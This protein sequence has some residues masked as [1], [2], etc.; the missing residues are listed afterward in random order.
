MGQVPERPSLDGLEA[1]WGAR[2]EADGTYRHDRRRPR[3]DVYAIDFPPLTVSGSLHVGH[4]F[5]YCHTDFLAR[6]QRMRGRAVFYPV[7]WDDNGLPT[8][9]R[10]ENHYG[11][12][13]DPSLPYDPDFSPP[14]RPPKRKLPISRPNFVELCRRLTDA[15]E[16]VFEDLWRQ[17]GLSVDWSLAYTTIG[18]RA[19][20]TSQR[21]FLHQLAAGEAYQAEA[22]TL[23]DVTYR[24]AVAQAEIEDREVQGTA[25][26]VRFGAGGAAAAGAGPGHG[27]RDLVVETTRPELLPACVALVAHP[28]DDRYRDLAG[29]TA[30]T[31]LFGVPV[32]V[33]AHRLADPGKGTGLAMICTFGD[34]TDVVWWREL[35]LPVRSV[36]TRDGRL[37]ADPP[38]GVPAN[39]AWAELAGQTT[40]EA[41]RRAVE[42]LLASGD[43]AGEPRTITHPVKFYEN[44]DRP[45][46]IV[47]SRQWFIC[48]LEH[49][50]RFLELG[51]ALQWQPP[52]MHTRYEH[53]VTG[54]HSD[55]LVS[56][57]RFFGVP[58]PLWYPLTA[59][60][61]VDHDHPIVPEE[62]R[63]PVDPSTDV[64]DG[65]VAA[66]R[67]RP[68]GFTGDPDVFD[69][70]ATS[71][72]TP[73]IA[74]GWVEDPERFATVFPMHLRP[75]AH[76]IIRTWLFYTIV[77]SDF[78]HGVLPWSRAAISGWVVDPDRRKMSKSKGNVVTP[79]AMLERY[80]ADAL[81]YWAAGGRPGTDTAVDEGQM[82]VGRR[83]A[84]KLLNSARFILGLADDG[85]DAGPPAGA[86]DLA[87]L[88]GLD[89]VVAGVTAALEACDWTAALE[90]VERFFWSFCD[91]YLELVKDRAYQPP[92]T[93]AGASA[94]AALRAGLDVQVR[95]LAPYLPYACEEVWSWWRDGT[96]HLAAWPEPA[97]AGVAA[98]DQ[99][100]LEAAS[101]V[102][103]AIRRAKSQARLPLRTPVAH[104]EV[105]GPPAWLA[106]VRAAEGDL[107]AA[108][109][110]AAFGYRER[111]DADGLDV[112]VELA[113][114]E[115][116]TT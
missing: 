8:E 19:R 27:R 89:A 1:K 13:C 11:V 7:G 107:A 4:V 61:E 83:L 2:W 92:G 115:E 10:V 33:V 55:W 28:D 84:I 30:T 112:R 81:R 64:P 106:A 24:T 67:G 114:A 95:L 34:T 104:A 26:R 9:R 43:L 57:Q 41:R 77:R 98:A 37:Q 46:E 74:G 82:R 60:G 17:L 78:E 12:R 94:R 103:A 71:S 22:P 79:T 80:G 23:W 111:P 32:P 6:F 102:I 69:T 110:V 105:T 53:W 59:S 54:L 97:P 45:L 20:R 108:G 99:R 39:A 15:D 87:M 36:V 109:R 56:R 65:H 49:R 25:V 58:I 63:L 76:E 29:T 70:W 113:A 68:G 73:Q 14:A 75:Q 116:A 90:R 101:Q 96:V 66:D 51:R 48:L 88:A 86:L 38:P 40:T 3:E 18:E 93:P 47:T 31:P 85:P 16:Q 50:E 35:R 91:D 52:W 44:G 72:L 21:G 100:P 42:L 62:A 5:S